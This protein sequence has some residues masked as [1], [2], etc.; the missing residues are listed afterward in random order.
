M[1][2]HFSKGTH[3]KKTVTELQFESNGGKNC[4]ICS[5]GR[6]SLSLTHSKILV[7]AAEINLEEIQLG[8]LAQKYS[9]NADVKSLGKMMETEHA[10][11]L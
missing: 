10:K 8:Q 4:Q 2:I 1:R 7:N 6:V 3:K 11:K 9:L 5:P